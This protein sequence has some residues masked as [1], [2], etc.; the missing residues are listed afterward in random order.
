[1]FIVVPTDGCNAISDDGHCYTS[2]TSTGINWEIARLECV[3]RGY[4]IATVTSSEE[5]TLMYNTRTSSS[6]CW[7]GLHDRYTDGT[8][9][10]A[11]GSNSTYREWSSGYLNDD[12]DSEDCAMTLDSL[13]WDVQSC[14]NTLTC[15]FC[16]SHG[17]DRFF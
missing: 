7:I 14:S 11:D 12:P 8:F 16:D 13:R 2:F 3:S 15:F 9:V 4:D 1:M 5:N 17:K 10:W 6:F